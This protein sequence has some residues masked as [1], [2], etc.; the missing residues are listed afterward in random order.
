MLTPSKLKYSSIMKQSIAS[1]PGSKKT[2]AYFLSKIKQREKDL[3]ENK[4]KLALAKERFGKNLDMLEVEKNRVNK[5]FGDVTDI[6]PKIRTKRNPFQSGFSP[7]EDDLYQLADEIRQQLIFATRDLEESQQKLENSKSNNDE[8]LSPIHDSKEIQGKKYLVDQF[9]R[10]LDKVNEVV[11]PR[12]SEVIDAENKAFLVLQDQQIIEQK[13]LDSQKQAQYLQKKIKHMQKKLTTLQE[14]NQK[15]KECH[16]ITK[17]S[18]KDARETS[19]Q[20]KKKEKELNELEQKIREK[21]KENSQ[22]NERIQ[23]LRKKTESIDNERKKMNVNREYEEIIP[24][25]II[26]ESATQQDIDNLKKE[27]SKAEERLNQALEREEKLNSDNNNNNSNSNKPKS[28]IEDMRELIKVA[29]E[30]NEKLKSSSKTNH[31]DDGDTL[32]KQV[33]L[34]VSSV[35]DIKSTIVPDEDLENR[36]AMLRDQQKAILDIEKKLASRSA[37]LHNLQDEIETDEI[38]IVQTEDELKRERNLYITKINHNKKL[39]NMY[40]LQKE[41][42]SETLS[43]LKKMRETLENEH[44]TLE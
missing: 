13:K 41:A 5:C 28:E 14:H 33:A 39:Y 37:Q 38:D 12:E 4:R 9:Q 30:E 42:M 20:L 21:E 22:L 29:K 6:S 19:E 34:K 3:K 40:V 25:N 32:K 11:V 8:N 18:L 24:S 17:S 26:N 35:H 15:V 10:L 31:I 36:D 27:V 7:G 16:E 43:D 1:D 23:D 44:N 2:N